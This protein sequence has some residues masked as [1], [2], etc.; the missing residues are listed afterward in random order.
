MLSYGFRWWILSF[1]G[2][3]ACV[4]S[5]L[6]LMGGHVLSAFAVLISLPALPVLSLGSFRARFLNALPLLVLS[7]GLYLGFRHGQ[8]PIA[9]RLFFAVPF[10]ALLL[11]P[12]R[13]PLKYVTV[14]V[15][16]ISL[17]SDYAFGFTYPWVYRILFIIWIYIIFM[18][19]V[20]LNRL[21]R[22]KHRFMTFT[23]KGQ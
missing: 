7:V 9:G 1:L 20:I 13:H 16:L 4:L 15:S 23:A 12:R 21:R 14:G 3:L 17:I 5:F 2:F 18:P 22:L 11:K 19:P 10:A 8:W 6:T